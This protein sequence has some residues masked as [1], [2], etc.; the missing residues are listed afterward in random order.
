MIIGALL[1]H[2]D[3]APTQRYAHLSDDPLRAA[4]D[5]ISGR[6][7]AAMKGGDEGGTEVVDLRTATRNKT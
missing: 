5:R 7:A 4:A 2:R 3:Q 1:G 6:I